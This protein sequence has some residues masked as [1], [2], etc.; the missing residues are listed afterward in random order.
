MPDIYVRNTRRW[1]MTWSSSEQWQ[2]H[3][4]INT[5]TACVVLLKLMDTGGYND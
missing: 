4:S 3:I 1:S 5:N 2:M